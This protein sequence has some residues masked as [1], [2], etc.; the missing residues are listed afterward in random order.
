MI[1]PV[2]E[3]VAGNDRTL[4]SFRSTA[5]PFSDLKYNN[6]HCLL[7]YCNSDFPFFI[8]AELGKLTIRLAHQKYCIPSVFF[9]NSCFHTEIHVPKMVIF[10][11]FRRQS[12][13]IPSYLLHSP[14]LILDRV[15]VFLSISLA[16]LLI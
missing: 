4:Y 2:F 14:S 6:I 15:D 5:R 7:F 8:P 13:Q 3:P 11:P 10:S 9:C 16:P 12:Q 1:P